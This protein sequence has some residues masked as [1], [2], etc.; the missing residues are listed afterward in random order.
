MQDRGRVLSAPGNRARPHVAAVTVGRKGTIA[1]IVVR[2]TRTAAVA[3]MQNL[4]VSHEKL[5]V[6]S[7]LI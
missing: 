7:G 6:D 2:P 4:K 3:F 5:D 1:P